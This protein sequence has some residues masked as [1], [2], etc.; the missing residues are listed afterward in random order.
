MGYLNGAKLFKMC[1]KNVNYY[2]DSLKKFWR[3]NLNEM[4]N[5]QW[6][7]LNQTIFFTEQLLTENK[8][9]K[10]EK[11]FEKIDF[12]KN[13][14]KNWQN[15]NEP[16]FLNHISHLRKL[17]DDS[18]SHFFDLEKLFLSENKNVS[19][20]SFLVLL[21]EKFGLKDVCRR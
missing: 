7:Q 8:I 10:W 15:L 6:K 9:E 16:V 4:T 18:Y 17:C 14:R 13:E 20:V 5:I 3:M 19:P 1:E 21:F 11:N 2:F 12:E